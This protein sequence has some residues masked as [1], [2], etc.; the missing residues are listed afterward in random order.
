MATM[1]ATLLNPGCA[2]LLGGPITSCQRE[3]PLRDEPSRRIRVAALVADIVIFFPS[4]IVDFADCAIYK[5]CGSPPGT[6]LAH[7]APGY[8]DSSLIN[9]LGPKIDTVRISSNA[10]ESPV[11]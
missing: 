11:K 5:P 3:I 9:A 7:P 4:V 6:V 2:T 10:P 1:G 8:R